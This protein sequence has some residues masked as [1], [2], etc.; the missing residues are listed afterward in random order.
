MNKLAIAFSAGAFG[1]LANS[2]AV[3]IFGYLGISAMLGVAIAPNLTA[4][5][6]Y[7]RLV[8]GGIWGFL[9]LLPFLK[10]SLFLKGALLSLAP[11]VVQLLL[12][13]P[14]QTN[15]GNLGLDLGLLTPLLVVFFNLVWGLAAAFIIQQ[16][17]FSNHTERA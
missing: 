7:P 3:W 8:W 15:K 1:G 11:T 17:A 9:F 12:I 2:I 5:W 13:F 16:T 6:L 10:R 14:Y 4:A